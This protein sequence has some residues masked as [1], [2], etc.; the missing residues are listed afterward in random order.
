MTNHDC[1]IFFLPGLG[2]GSAS[3]APLAEALG[4][5]FRVVGIDLPGQGRTPDAVNGSV[6]ALAD[7]ALKTI[8]AEADG[9]P[10]LL[11]AHSMG[12]KVAALVAARVL[13]GHEA[14][15]G[16][17]GAVLLA[18]SPPTP[19]PMD[20]DKRAL[21]LS[22][23]ENGPLSEVDAREFVAQNVATSLVAALEQDA[24]DQVRQMSPLAWQ[25]W[26]REG[27]RENISAA[28]G[29]IDLPVVVMGG[30]DDDDL[31][32]SVQPRLLGAVYPRARFVSLAAT[33][34]L[35]PY[36][37]P[38]EVAA[39]IAR[40]WESIVSAS[41]P[42]APEWG[43]LIAS[44]RTGVEAR[45]LLARRA[46]ADDVDY[47]PRAL[48]PGQLATLRA[49]ADRLVPQSEARRIDLAARIDA[50]LA[51]GRGD[52]WRPAELPD[53]AAAYRLGLDAIASVWADGVERQDALIQG[54]IAGEFI[55]DAPWAGDVFRRWFE[56]V[57]NDLTRTWLAHPASLARVGY[58]GFATSGPGAEPAGYVGLG[59]GVRD[60]W[61]PADLGALISDHAN[62]PNEN[63]E[64]SDSG[65][66]GT[67]NNAGQVGKENAA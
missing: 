37:Q 50:D 60:S 19:E 31:G 17:A 55:I 43:R 42:V 12:G 8:E 9:G 27:S 35:L 14:V 24:V 62:R 4:D 49:L 65:D 6:H 13:S 33:G 41:P 44:D 52:G 23:A 16:L 54:I 57:R 32:A 38:H 30:E 26:L 1:T 39:E 2:F 15:F 63:S 36:E 11:A 29:V 47:S 21:M 66:P 51:S 59:A 25:R 46:I 10:C 61:E 28:V 22:W 7:A 53:D 67:T 45:A 56:D 3:T 20:D 48:S 40:F 18:P 58:D 5:R 64:N 34:H